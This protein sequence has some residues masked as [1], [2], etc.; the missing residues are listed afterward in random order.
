MSNTNGTCGANALQ[1]LIGKSRED[2]EAMTFDA[3]NVRIIRPGM[4]VTMDH[5]ESR[6][7][8]L[9][10]ENNRVSRVYCG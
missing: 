6:L 7:N 8:I 4:M 2:V 10:D 3:K 5:I 9:L 1:H